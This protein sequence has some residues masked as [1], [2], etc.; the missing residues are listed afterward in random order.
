MLDYIPAD[1]LAQYVGC[2]VSVAGWIHR[3]RRMG[4]LTFI[5][6][7]D[8]QGL[9]QVVYRPDD[10][11]LPS[12]DPE[13]VVEVEGVAT[14]EVRAP[15]GVE[16]GSPTVRVLSGPVGRLPLYLG[17]PTLDA[18]LDLRLIKNGADPGSRPRVHPGD[19][20]GTTRTSAPATSLVKR[21]MRLSA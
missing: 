18:G 17:G 14:H 3:V 4:G 8:G 5:V 11:P 9:V 10:A 2:P 1:K 12:L 15:G 21:A 16:L 7:R 19:G 13:T 20:K 6:V